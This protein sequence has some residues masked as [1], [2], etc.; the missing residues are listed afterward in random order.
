MTLRF[1]FPECQYGPDMMVR[2][3]T[4]VANP[5]RKSVSHADDAQLRDRVLF[6]ELGDKL[7]RVAECEE[8]ARRTEVLLRHGGREVQD[9]DQVSYDAA[10]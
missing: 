4:H 7:L 3:P 9:E 1:L 8:V 5:D 10:L 6:E 2:I